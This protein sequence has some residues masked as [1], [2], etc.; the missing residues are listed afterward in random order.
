MRGLALVACIPLVTGCFAYD[1]GAKKWAYVGDTV[2]V[3]GGGGMIAGD[4]LTHEK[5][6]GTPCP[7]FDPPFSGAAVAGAILVVAGIIGMLITATRT[8]VKTSR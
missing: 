2:L 6:E 3:V 5:C 7:S 4:I 1:P 8:P